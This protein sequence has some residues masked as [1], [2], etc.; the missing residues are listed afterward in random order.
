MVEKSVTMNKGHNKQQI[1]RSN[2]YADPLQ[3]M[4]LPTHI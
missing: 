4:V 3:L 2:E 1:L